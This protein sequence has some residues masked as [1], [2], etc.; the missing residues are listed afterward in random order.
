MSFQGGAAWRARIEADLGKKAARLPQA[1]DDDA[2]GTLMT[3]L[4]GHCMATLV[5]AF[6]AAQDD[7]P[8]LFIAWTVKGFGLPFA[9]HKDNHSGLM[10]PTQAARHARRDGHF[11]RRR[12]AA[13]RRDRR[14]RF[15]RGQAL[16]RPQPHPARQARAIVRQDRNS[17]HR[18]AA[19][20]EQAT[21][22]AFGKIML[23]L[24]RAGGDLAD[25]IVTTSPDVTVSTNLGAWVNQ[26]GLFKRR[27]M[28]D[29]F[30]AAKIASAQKWAATIRASTSSWGSRNPIFS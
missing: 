7:V 16:A 24:S 1:H 29:V 22:A 15:A 8:T 12:M 13:A 30:A 23:D 6:D 10:N 18:R 19:G 2:L 5:E 21:Q 14:Q 17:R 9:G 26:R 3:D 11:R 25:R 27:E 4:G 20:D 28:K